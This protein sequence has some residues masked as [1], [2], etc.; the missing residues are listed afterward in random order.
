MS[1]VL[2]AGIYDDDP[3]IITLSKSDFGKRLNDFSVKT[4]HFKQVFS[5]FSSFA[6]IVFIMLSILTI[7][8]VIIDKKKIN[9]ITTTVRTHNFDL[10]M[11]NSHVQ[12]FHCV[13]NIS[14]YAL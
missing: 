12:T 4:V 13:N 14:C 11:S 5:F 10:G 3:E 2:I 8:V 6:V 9:F 7:L 1:C